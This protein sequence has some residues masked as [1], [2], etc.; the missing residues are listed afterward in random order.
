MLC[1]LVFSFQKPFVDPCFFSTPR[2][3]NSS[4]P[5]ITLKADLPGRNL[6]T[7]R[8]VSSVQNP[9]PPWNDSIFAPENGWL[10]YDRF[11]L[12]PGQFSGAFAVSFR[13]CM[14]FHYTDWFIVG[15]LI[16]A[17]LNLYITGEYIEIPPKN[18][19]NQ[20][21]LVTAQ[22][23][24]QMTSQLVGGFSQPV[25]KIL[26]KFDT[27]SPRIG[28]KIKHI[29]NPPPSLELTIQRDFLHTQVVLRAFLV[30]FSFFCW[31]ISEIL[32]S[33]KLTARTWR[34][35]VGIR[36]CPFGKVYFK[37]RTVSGTNQILPIW[38]DCLA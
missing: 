25:W 35:M 38:K 37:G 26:A 19:I 23:D 4:P 2:H 16:S 32:P 12:G 9:Y 14:T 5:A 15:I 24:L 29:W 13:E 20:G 1:F 30:C 28:V 8:E 11:L 10:E 36:S 27:F 22:A 34:W 3:P 7:P 18:P 31:V 17:S 21:P 33:L 6:E